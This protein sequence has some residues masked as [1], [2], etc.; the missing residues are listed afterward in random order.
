MRKENGIPEE[1]D[2][3]SFLYE[4]RK[5]VVDNIY[6]VSKESGTLLYSNK[7][8]VKG[9]KNQKCYKVVYGQDEPCEFCISCRYWENKIPGTERKKKYSLM[10]MDIRILPGVLKSSGR[11]NLLF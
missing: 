9:N 8:E 4:E 5:R 11:E 1:V 6:V 2:Q 7:T 3:F 10:Q